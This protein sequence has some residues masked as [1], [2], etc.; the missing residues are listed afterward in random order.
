MTRDEALA[1]LGLNDKSLRTDI[2]TRYA[3]L[4]KRY[5]SEQDNDKL[6]EISLAY[7]IV[8]GRYVEPVEDTP[9]MKKVVFGRTRKDWS[10]IWLYNKYKFLAIVTGTAVLI[11]FIVTIVTN[12]PGDIKIAA[13]GDFYLPESETVSEYVL[14]LFEEFERVD[15]T[16]AYIGSGSG[17]SGYDAAGEQKAMIL[18]TV[19][20][21][22]VIIVNRMIFD[23][24]AS[25]GAFT[26]LDDFF[27]EISAYPEA[28]AL[29]L[30][31]V[32]AR[33]EESENT[34]GDEHVYGIDLGSTQLLNAIGIIGREQ[35]L[36]VSIKS[37]DSEVAKEF[38]RRLI[39]DSGNVLPLVTPIAPPPTPSPTPAPTSASA[40]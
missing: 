2:E 10:N 12:K 29:G 40:P 11:Y 4:V 8:T 27:N 24:Y 1:I 28:Q 5:R 13:V 15:V 23:R 19:S 14:S 31:A 35:I 33:V 26:E 20:G 9:E 16:S 6:E 25:M 7:N 38:I 37:K 17:G 30:Q 32:K 22:D 34:M 18:M 3:T 21:E 36:T 39:V